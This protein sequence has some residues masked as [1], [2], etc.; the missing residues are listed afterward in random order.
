[1][2]RMQMNAF[3]MLSL[4]NLMVPSRQ[5]TLDFHKG[6]WVFD[7]G[8]KVGHRLDPGQSL[9]S[10]GWCIRGLDLAK[11]WIVPSTNTDVTPDKGD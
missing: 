8:R 10:N 9:G 6:V 7:S 3:N 5:S 4:T 11:A 1:M 2:A